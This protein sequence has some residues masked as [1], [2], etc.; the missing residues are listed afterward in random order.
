MSNL[1]APDK[2]VCPRCQKQVISDGHELRM[3]LVNAHPVASKDQVLM[4]DVF[5]HAC[6]AKIWNVTR[7][8]WYGEDR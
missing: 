1:L 2:P 4:H 6:A 5:H 8:H 3:E 7:R